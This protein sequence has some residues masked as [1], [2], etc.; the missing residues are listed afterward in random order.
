MHYQLT[1]FAAVMVLGARREAA[2]YHC[3]M[4]WKRM[5]KKDIEE[6]NNLSPILRILSI[7]FATT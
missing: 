7:S 2:G 5:P 1:F 4:V 6:V 3:V